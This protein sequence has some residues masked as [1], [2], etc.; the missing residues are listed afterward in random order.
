MIVVVTCSSPVDCETG[1][2]LVAAVGGG[3]EALGVAG[4]VGSAAGAGADNGSE[5]R[6]DDVD[7]DEEE[8]APGGFEPVEP[9]NGLNIGVRELFC[10]TGAV[11]AENEGVDKG[12]K[13]VLFDLLPIEDAYFDWVRAPILLV[14]DVVTPRSAFGPVDGNMFANFVSLPSVSSKL[15]NL[16]SAAS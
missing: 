11:E 1:L 6:T 8:E 15:A 14:L 2:V 16:E 10:G 9:V 13:S 7:D 3:T 5:R 12:L 4:V